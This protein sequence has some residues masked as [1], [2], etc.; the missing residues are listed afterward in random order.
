MKLRDFIFAMFT[1]IGIGIPVALIC[2]ITIGG[3]NEVV[4]EFWCGQ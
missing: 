4:M 2:M 1:G 3:F